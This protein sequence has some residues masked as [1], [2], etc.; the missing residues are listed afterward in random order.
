MSRQLALRWVV[1][2]AAVVGLGVVFVLQN[3]NVALFF[4]LSSNESTQFLINR[5][6]RFILNDLLTI[7][8]IFALFNDRKYVIFAFWVQLIGMIFFLIPYL[9]MKSYFPLYN[10]PLINY[11]HRLILNPILLLLLIPAFYFQRFNESGGQKK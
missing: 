6:V 7:L 8:L 10:G 2:F 1:G 3:A 11:V 4:H 9:V 5:I